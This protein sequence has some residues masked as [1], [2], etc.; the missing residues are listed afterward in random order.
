MSEQARYWHDPQFGGLELLSARY[1][2]HRFLPHAHQTYALG[3]IEA[4]AEGYRY[5]GA[6][7]VAPAGSV[8][9][10]APDELHTGEAAHSGGWTYRMLYPAAHWLEEAHAAQGGR[11]LPGFRSS[12]LHDPQLAALLRRAHASFAGPASALA[13][14]TVLRSALAALV[15][16][17]ADARPVGHRPPVAS[18]RAARDLLDAEPARNLTLSALA[19]QVGLS[20]HHL[21][22]AFRAAYGVPPHAYQLGARVRLARDL[23]VAGQPAVQA[24][25]AAGFADQAHL[26]RTFKRVV[27][28][29]P[30]VY[31]RARRG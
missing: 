21:A 6:R 14:E 2:R 31:Q 20:P 7:V 1:V 19:A 10:I 17:H 27:G 26:T 22:R 30:G 8:V 24:A 12:V 23:L 13:R 11:G 4:G 15:A 3:V 5:R 25:L 29:T 9:V 28:V 16:R 18:V